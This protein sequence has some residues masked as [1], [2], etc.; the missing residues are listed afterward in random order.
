MS[1]E[2]YGEVWTE[3][4]DNTLITRVKH[5]FTTYTNEENMIT[6]YDYYT[7]P[8]T[9]DRS[10]SHYVVRVYGGRNGSGEWTSYFED[11][12]NAFAG[13]VNDSECN[14]SSVWL[15]ELKN[16]PANDTFAALIGLKD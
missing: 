3:T 9:F 16:S 15:I 4:H 2:D 13:L 6:S 7:V 11:M 1:A 8:D 14:F 5:G 12:K 10:R